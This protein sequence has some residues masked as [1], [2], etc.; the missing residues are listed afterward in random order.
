MTMHGSRLTGFHED[1]YRV[2]WQ[3]TQPE[4][5]RAHELRAEVFCRELKWV[6]S[7]DDALERDEF[8]GDSVHIGV[9]EGGTRLVASV[10]L[11][12]EGAPWM[13]DTV[14]QHL[15][16]API[17]RR[18]AME[19]SRLAV[20]TQS[21]NV[22]LKNGRRVCDL[23][24]KSAYAYCSLRGVRY[25][26]MVTSDIVLRHMTRA[27]LP[28]VPL[29]RPKRMPDG[30]AAVPVVLNWDRIRDVPALR[31]WYDEGWSSSPQLVSPSAAASLESVLAGAPTNVERPRA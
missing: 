4:L 12:H 8:D 2:S 13:L 3:L 27:C 22:R 24:Y 9:F 5:R 16:P 30:V 11:T 20:T 1:D 28:C 31:R 26:Y 10:R 19:A 29:A 17:Q 7:R 18:H 25:L 21:R 6:G 14:F 23:L 15:L